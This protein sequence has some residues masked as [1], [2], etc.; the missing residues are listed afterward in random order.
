MI[1]QASA[2]MTQFST[3]WQAPGPILGVVIGAIPGA[4]FA[5]QLPPERAAKAAE[6]LPD[7]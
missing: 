1:W 3:A 2:N 4:A 5:G 6:E 7:E